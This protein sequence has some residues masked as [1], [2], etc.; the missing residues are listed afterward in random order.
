[1]N[2]SLTLAA[3]TLLTATLALPAAAFEVDGELQWSKRLTLSTPVTGVVT[4]AP[5]APGQRVAKGTLLV[6]LDPRP[7][8]AR[9]ARAAAG[10]ASAEAALG[11]ARREMERAEELYDRTVLSDHELQKARIGLAAAEA[12]FESARA[13][14]TLA[15]VALERSR[16]T[17][18]FDAWVLERPAEVGETVVSRLEARPL[19]VLAEAGRMVA[20]V[21]V[22]A[23]RA[24]KLAPGMAA[25]V[26]VN[27][28]RYEGRVRTVALE[29]PEGSSLYP[30][31][32]EFASDQPLRAGQRA[33]VDLP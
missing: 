8:A 29:A 19:V 32:V 17:A 7:F 2:R 4:E 6:R 15:A 23:D 33:S 1:M 3:A 31:E 10:V 24:A 26:T 5:V 12:A 18:P 27:G 16:L 9:D 30:V 21:A 11:E 25:A 28:D 22:G 13:E 14:R 20:R